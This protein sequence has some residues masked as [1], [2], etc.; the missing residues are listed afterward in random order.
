[1]DDGVS[2]STAS[3]TQE[4]VD[5]LVEDVQQFGGIS[6]SDPAPGN[7]AALAWAWR[8]GK[9]VVW[10]IKRRFGYVMSSK[11]YAQDLP[12]EVG[13]LAYKA[14]RIHNAVEE[15]RNN[16]FNV[17]GEVTEWQASAHK[18]LNDAEDLLGYFEKESKTCCYGT[19][20]DSNFHYQE[21]HCDNAFVL[22][23]LENHEARRL[24]ETELGGKV[25]VELE[26]LV[27][28]ALSICAGLPFLILAIAKLFTDT[29]YSECKDALKQIW[30]EETGEVINKTLRVSY[31]RIKREEAKSLLRLCVACGVSKPPL[32][33]LVRYGM[34]LRLFQEA[35]SMEEA[36]ESLGSLIHILKA[37]SLLSEDEDEDGNGFK[38]HDMVRGFVTSVAS[39]D[40]P[41]LILEGNN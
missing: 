28:E 39:R 8:E 38:I 41:L 13:K 18:A 29:T 30:N 23:G 35:S 25:Q 11:R 26:P 3:I 19:L 4:I 32:E 12:K 16:L 24:F 34:G 1:M 20:H 40:H 17:D 6:F 33:Y 2:K 7:V 36:R 9:D 21:M 10:S 15:A 5:A 14:E 27:E 31:D 22:Y 37:S